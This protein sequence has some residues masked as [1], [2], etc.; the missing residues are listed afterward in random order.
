MEEMFL[1]TDYLF[2]KYFINL[3]D[4]EFYSMVVKAI[5]LIAF[6]NEFKSL[7]NICELCNFRYQ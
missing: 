7:S 1:K 6:E 4:S 3:N 5:F 2:S